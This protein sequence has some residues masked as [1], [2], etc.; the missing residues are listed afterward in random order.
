M[1]WRAGGEGGGGDI[2]PPAMAAAKI[3]ALKLTA[4]SARGHSV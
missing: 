2:L 3:S 4:S 1:E